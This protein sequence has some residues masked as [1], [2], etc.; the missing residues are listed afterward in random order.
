MRDR[1]Y[2]ALMDQSCSL[3]DCDYFKIHS[4]CSSCLYFSVFNLFLRHCANDL[5]VGIFKSPTKMKIKD[6]FTKAHTT[7]KIHGVF[8]RSIHLPSTLFCVDCEFS[9]QQNSRCFDSILSTFWSSLSC[10]NL[11]GD[12]NKMLQAK[13]LERHNSLFQSSRGLNVKCKWC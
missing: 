10:V 8:S 12:Q 6:K 9:L 5:C 7:F 3:H 11:K 4:Q 1:H 13:C 2:L